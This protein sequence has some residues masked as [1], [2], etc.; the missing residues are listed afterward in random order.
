MNLAI[1]LPRGMQFSAEGATSI[2]LVARDLVLH[3]RF[4]ETTLVF[5]P[6]IE[7]PFPG[8]DFR[9]LQES[10]QRARQR[11]I[12][13]LLRRES[14]DAVIVH[15]HPA[16]ASFL[17]KHLPAKPVLLYRHGLLK[18]RTN[19]WS[20]WLRARAFAKLD[21]IVFVSRFLREMFLED[22]PGLAD[23]SSVINN[24]VDTA[25]WTPSAEK[26]QTITYLGRARQDKGIL[27]L[28]E[29]VRLMDMGDW[30]LQLVIAVQ[31]EAERVFA[32][33]VR[34]MIRPDEPIIVRENLT[35]TDVR[36][37][38]AQSRIVALPSIVREGFPR[39]V[40]EAM[41]CGCATI[42]TRSGGTPEAAGEA[43]LMLDEVTPEGLSKALS[44]LIHHPDQVDDWGQK[45]RTHV[46][47]TLGID[48]IGR[49]LDAHLAQ[50]VSGSEG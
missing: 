11:E 33:Q 45:A 27:E 15:Q 16:T 26:N 1:V 31:T 8:F 13:A 39:A 3:S 22:Y 41:A 18:R 37:A 6:A 44:H 28:I 38:L 50:M 36:D 10:S 12:L 9:P 30:Q 17:K 40:V 34:V 14:V 2:D 25:F 7:R 20:R 4:R 46:V 49:Q 32:D 47:D 23:Q 43:V 29:A 24:G 5:G 21:H 35:S 42:A 48:V 19:W